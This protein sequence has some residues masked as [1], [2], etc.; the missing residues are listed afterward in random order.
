MVRDKMRRLFLIPAA[1]LAACLAAPAWADNSDENTIPEV[2]SA[3]KGDYLIVAAGSI[4]ASDYDGSDDY[5]FAPAAGFRARVGDVRLFS[6][7]IGIGAD[8]IPDARSSDVSFS[9]GPVVRYRANRSGKV[10]DRVVRLLP[11]LDA[12]FEAGITMGVS[13]DGLI[14]RKDSLSFGSDV[15]W[16]VSGNKGGRIITADVSYFTPVSRAAGIGFSFGASHVNRDFADY[17]YSVD[18]AGSGASGL[19]LYRAKGGWKNW[20]ARLVAGYDLDGNLLNGGWAVGGAISYT[21]LTGS[22]ARTPITALRGSR[23][24]W[25]AGAGLAYTF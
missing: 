21:R 11:E 9:L 16:T 20:S 3:F 2:D 5:R 23:S 24:Q 4:Y 6:R 8:F 10:R 13:F 7:A 1:L 17:N 19:P 22:A 15:R 12:T 25:L 14:T 18:P